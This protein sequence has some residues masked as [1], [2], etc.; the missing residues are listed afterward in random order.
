[1]VAQMLSLRPFA[2]CRF[3]RG[4]GLYSPASIASHVVQ[5]IDRD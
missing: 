2:F 1:M 5:P 3:V 4:S